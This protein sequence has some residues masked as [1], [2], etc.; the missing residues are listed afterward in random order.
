MSPETDRRVDHQF[1]G[2]GSEKCE[3]LLQEDRLVE[4]SAGHPSRCGAF[5]AFAVL[6]SA[7]RR[8]LLESGCSGA[9][10]PHTRF[11]PPNDF[12]APQAGAPETPHLSTGGHHSSG[13]PRRDSP[14]KPS[15]A[16]SEE[17]S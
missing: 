14:Y 9:L 1:A 2:L 16:A 8:E 5:P 12:R 10:S 7:R 15:S 17:I 6:K 3:A 11:T 13:P 4:S